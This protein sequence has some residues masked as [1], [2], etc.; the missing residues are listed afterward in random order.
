MSDTV[1]VDAGHQRFADE[2]L[3]LDPLEALVRLGHV[4][5]TPGLALERA[6]VVVR[7]RRVQQTTTRKALSFFSDQLKEASD[8]V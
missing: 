6:G 4:F 1:S 8:A 3:G 2:G 5:D 7:A